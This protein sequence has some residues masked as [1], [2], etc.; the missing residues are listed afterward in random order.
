[1]HVLRWQNLWFEENKTRQTIVI[2]HLHGHHNQHTRAT[3]VRICHN[4][5][6]V[7]DSITRITQSQ[8][9][10][11]WGHTNSINI[12][13]IYFI[14]F[15]QNLL[16]YWSLFLWF[17]GSLC[18]S[19]FSWLKKRQVC[20]TINLVRPNY[21]LAQ[22]TSRSE[23]LFSINKKYEVRTYISSEFDT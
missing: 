22:T 11:K 9:A 10:K 16:I 15:D 21:N 17:S 14:P 23:V 2:K 12:F 13:I 8:I 5:S 7:K 3:L 6:L 4:R 19:C 18:F 1:M 20:H